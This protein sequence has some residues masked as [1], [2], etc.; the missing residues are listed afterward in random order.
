MRFI[1][2][3]SAL[4]TLNRHIPWLVHLLEAPNTH[5]WHMYG[6]LRVLAGEMSS[7]FDNMDCLGRESSEGAGLPEYNHEEPRACF[8]PMC[9]LMVKLL[10]DIGH[11]ESKI[12]PLVPNPPYF[13]AEIPDDFITPACRYW[14]SIRAPQLTNEA[15]DSFPRFAKL[16]EQDRLNLIIA[17]A[18]SGVP[19][20]RIAGTPPGFL[21]RKDSAW[22][23]LD[24]AHPLWKSIVDHGRVSLFWENAPEGAEARL[25]ATGQ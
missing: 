11:D 18:V 7:F 15:A 23:S 8:D 5:P 13:S 9:A 14:L 17:K 10:A 12:L 19:M 22:Y 4:Q 25:V 2:S 16:G 20:T 21:R 24:T 6:A 3:F 1:L